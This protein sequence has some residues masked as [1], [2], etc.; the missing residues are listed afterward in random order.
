MVTFSLL[1]EEHATLGLT[2]KRDRLRLRPTPHVFAYAGLLAI[3]GFMLPLI[4]LSLGGAGV[5]LV[6]LGAVLLVRAVLTAAAVVVADAEHV[7]IRNR[8]SWK[9]IPIADVGSVATDHRHFPFGKSPYSNFWA[10][11]RYLVVGY[12]TQGTGKRVYCDVATSPPPGQ[13]ML[14][15]VGLGGLGTGPGE[16][17]S[18]DVKMAALKRWV[19]LTSLRLAPHPRRVLNAKDDTA[20]LHDHQDVPVDPGWRRAASGEYRQNRA[21]PARGFTGSTRPLPRSRAL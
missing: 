17:P 4:G 3:F 15:L 8:A 19:S 2:Y 12:V 5:V 9:R 16:R 20:T 7:T 10:G 6:A 13:T 11:P 21:I 18:A 1:P 14:D